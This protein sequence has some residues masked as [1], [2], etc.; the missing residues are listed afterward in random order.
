M[1]YR[2]LSLD[3]GGTWSL[4][5]VRALIQ[6][7]GMDTSGHTILRDFDLVAANSG[8]SLVLAGL[9]ED[10][11]LSK[12]LDYFEDEKLRRSIFSPTRSLGDR[13]VRDLTGLGPKYSAEARLPVLQRLLPKSGNVSLPGSVAGIRRPGATVDVHLLI[14]GFDYDRNRATFFRSAAASGPSWGTGE[15]AN[16]TL[17]EAVHAS[18]NAPVNY[19][20]APSQFPDRPERY[21]DGAI[22][23]CNNPVQAAVTEALVLNQKPTNIVALSLGTA[24]V[25]LPWPEPDKPPSAYWQKLGT[26]SLVADLHKLATSI[27]DDPPDIATFLAHVMTGADSDLVPPAQSRIVRMNPLVSPVRDGTANWKAPDDMTAAQFVCLA[28]LDLDAVQQHEVD[29]ITGYADLW[30]SDKAPNQPIRMNGDTLEPEPELGHARFQQAAAAWQIIEAGAA[31]P[32]PTPT[33]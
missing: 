18:T 21:W 29:A 5:Q 25:A 1:H 24:S 8:G 19:F 31:V 9:V 27:L 23:G 6:L 12:V 17:A 15:P 3:G 20:D 16:V 14:T 33:V 28:N 11:T 13:A 22:T 4:I 30:L 7:Y 26:P 2:I 32:Q 10:L